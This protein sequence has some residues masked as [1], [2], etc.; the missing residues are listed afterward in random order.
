M[1]KQ[2]SHYLKMFF[3]FISSINSWSEE[4]LM[5]ATEFTLRQI[6]NVDLVYK[7][8]LNQMNEKFDPLCT[9]GGWIERVEYP[10][11][12]TK[13]FNHWRFVQNPTIQTENYHRNKDDLT[14][15]L[16]N[17]LPGVAN[18]T[19]SDRWSYN[20]AFK[21]VAGLFLEAFS[22]LHTSE[23]F[24][25]DRFIDGDDSGKKFMIKYKGREMS[26]LEFWDTGC[27]RYT[28]RTP[29]TESEWTEFHNHVDRLILK[30]PNPPCETNITWNQAVNATFNL[31]KDI[32]Y[33]VEYGKELKQDYIDQC[34]EI[35]DKNLICAAYNWG[36]LLKKFVLPAAVPDVPT[37]PISSS[38]ALAWGTL[39]LLV[40]TLAYL[41]WYYYDIKATQKVF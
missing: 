22:P 23:H 5:L 25:N 28:L 18:Y 31:T 34:L 4:A 24:D 2:I 6:D 33:K 40:P 11:T 1:Q 29:Y 21:V 3:V 26:L 19:I 10:P 12:N 32:V 27:A 36:T 37:N 15:Q 9:V 14:I 16:T 17:L 13:C 35:T 8:A 30:Y 7:R 38:E 20:F 39:L 41:L